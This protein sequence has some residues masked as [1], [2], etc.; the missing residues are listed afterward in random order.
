MEY[1]C[2]TRA[3]FLSLQ[4]CTS[5]RGT[6]CRS[7]SAKEPLIMGL[8]CGTHARALSLPSCTSLSH[9]IS[10]ARTLSRSFIVYFLSHS[11]FSQAA[12]R[13]CSGRARRSLPPSLSLTRPLSRSLC[14]LSPSLSRA[15]ARTHSLAHSTCALSVCFDFSR[16]ALWTHSLCCGCCAKHRNAGLV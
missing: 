2:G 9:S 4:S 10:R 13:R 12:L 16:A 3:R 11:T 5:K 15:R 8:I 1:F 6:S 14:C 7:L